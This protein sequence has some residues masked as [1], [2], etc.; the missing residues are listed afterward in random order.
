MDRNVHMGIRAVLGKLARAYRADHRG[1][2][3]SILFRIAAHSEAAALGMA[4]AL[5]AIVAEP[6][7]RL[8]HPEG[9]S[10]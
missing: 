7:A 1:I 8:H 2:L 9:A 10:R 5:A 6:A 3:T 4:A